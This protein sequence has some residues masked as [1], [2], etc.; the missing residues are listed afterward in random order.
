[1]QHDVEIIRVCILCMSLYGISLLGMK[2]TLT[3]SYRETLYDLG[4][5]FFVLKCVLKF[6]NMVK[7]CT[8]FL[9]SVLFWIAQICENVVVNVSWD[10]DNWSSRSM[11]WITKWSFVDCALN[12]HY[13]RDFFKV[14]LLMLKMVTTVCI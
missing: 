11:L 6:K 2:P 13:N 14:T 8:G 3:R 1:M 12:V 9:S 10:I 5:F 4:M 7:S